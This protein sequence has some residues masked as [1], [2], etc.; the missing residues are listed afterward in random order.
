[1]MKN[2]K[3]V[4]FIIVV[5]F[6]V[7]YIVDGMSPFTTKMSD[8]EI[9]EIQ[10]KS[11]PANSD[12]GDKKYH[13]RVGKNVEKQAERE[14]SVLASIP[15]NSYGGQ[16]RRDKEKDVFQDRREIY[17]RFPHLKT[18]D[19]NED[20]VLFND[21]DIDETLKVVSNKEI[22]KSTIY[23][24]RHHYS[25]LKDGEDS[26]INV[27]RIDLIKQSLKFDGNPIRE[28]IVEMTESLISDFP[29][30]EE[31]KR[32]SEES[33]KAFLTDKVE[34]LYILEMYEP[35]SYSSLKENGSA[36]LKKLIGYAEKHRVAIQRFF[37]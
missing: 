22:I 32:M 18:T 24:I 34:L 33:Q 25:D 9:L 8:L 13:P 35:A 30:E 26:L 29:S 11:K 31:K 16:Y 6:G 4:L 28:S 37:Q 1:M 21:K 20:R 5:A 12:N 2:V 14:G 3:M 36:K 15:Q 17:R 23:D 10:K 27:M 7:F 19:L